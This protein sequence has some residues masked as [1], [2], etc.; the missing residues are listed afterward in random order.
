[1]VQ[2]ASA[3]IEDGVFIEVKEGARESVD[4]GIVQ[5]AIE[6]IGKR[7]CHVAGFWSPIK[8]GPSSRPNHFTNLLLNSYILTAL[9]ELFI[10]LYC[11][12][13]N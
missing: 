6:S 10:N 9:F 8:S 12:M 13:I 11:L 3:H 5:A 1:M 7:R 4:V 2:L